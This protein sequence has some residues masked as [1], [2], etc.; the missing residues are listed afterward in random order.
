MN[1]YIEMR[2]MVVI[3]VSPLVK[4]LQ[5]PILKLHDDRTFIVRPGDLGCG[6]L[7]PDAFGDALLLP[8]LL[9]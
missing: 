5:T 8:Y 1:D 7:L 3:S 4:L 2:G 6:S 9:S